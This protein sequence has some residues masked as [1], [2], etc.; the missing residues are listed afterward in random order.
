MTFV[1]H[2]ILIAIGYLWLEG[3]FLPG[4]DLAFLITAAVLPVWALWI[5]RRHSVLRA[6]VLGP[7][8]AIVGAA[9][10]LIWAFVDPDSSPLG[11]LDLLV[12]LAAAGA[13]AVY[14]VYCGI[15]FAAGAALRRTPPPSG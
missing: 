2:G 12:L 15:V 11:H 1:P 14:T 8:T 5:G 3:V 13:L 10:L 7:G 4:S 9:A 6:L